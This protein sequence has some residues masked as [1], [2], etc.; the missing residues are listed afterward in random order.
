MG[1][2]GEVGGAV[3]GGILALG[4]KY[5]RGSQAEKAVTQQAYQKTRE[6]MEAF[7]RVQGSCLCRTLLGG[8]DLRTP[9][10]MQRFKDEDLRH[11]VCVRCVRT[12]GEILEELLAAPAANPEGGQ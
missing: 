9:E 6:L 8:C 11:K 5:G 10:G 3:T 12:V 4:L 2:S 7:Q 1:G